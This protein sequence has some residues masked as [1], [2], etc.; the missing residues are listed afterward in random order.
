MRPTGSRPPALVMTLMPFAKIV[1]NKGSRT[2]EEN[3][4]MYPTV[5]WLV[6]RGDLHDRAR[7]PIVTSM[8]CQVLDVV[9]LHLEQWCMTKALATT[10][11]PSS[12]QRDSPSWHLGLPPTV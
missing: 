4:V 6:L 1:S 12:L 5:G 2:R 11:R 3:S 7:R 9:Q 8:K 10:D